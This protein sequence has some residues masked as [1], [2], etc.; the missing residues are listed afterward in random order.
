[1]K[2]K[3][4]KKTTRKKPTPKPVE[5]SVWW[6]DD[7][8]QHAAGIAGDINAVMVEADKLERWAKQLRGYE[9]RPVMTPQAVTFRVTEAEAELLDLVY[10]QHSSVQTTDRN[11]RIA[12]AARWMVC[13]A[14]TDLIGFRNA[15]NRSVTYCAAEGVP[16]DHYDD[17]Q[18]RAS[19]ADYKA[20]IAATKA[21]AND[22]DEPG[23]EW[24]RGAQR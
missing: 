20:R 17:A 24:K 5:S 13:H 2:R 9:Q 14:L 11:T 3:T 19:L 18:V 7:L 4:P 21:E 10:G 16:Q 12:A 8:R 1:M 15:V 23:D 22:G 6:D